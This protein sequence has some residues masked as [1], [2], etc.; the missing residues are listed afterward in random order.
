M[1]DDFN[2]VLDSEIRLLKDDSV[3]DPI[4]ELNVGDRRA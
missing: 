4:K 3:T 1:V 2:D